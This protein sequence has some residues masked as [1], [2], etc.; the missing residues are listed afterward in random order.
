MLLL[1][2]ALHQIYCGTDQTPQQLIDLL[3]NGGLYPPVD[4][5]VGARAVYDAIAASDVC[6]PQES[7]LKLHL[8]SVR[9]RMAAGIVRFL[10]WLDTRDM[11][12]DG[13]GKGAISR[14]PLVQALIQGFWRVI[15]PLVSKLSRKVIINEA[16][17]D[18]QLFEDLQK[19]AESREKCI[20]K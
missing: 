9:D 8:I 5:C 18:D 6:D 17:D 19:R 1:Q 20:D 16:L 12:A 3:E 10:F 11:L 13:L 14:K 2:A 7:S 15:H 4:L